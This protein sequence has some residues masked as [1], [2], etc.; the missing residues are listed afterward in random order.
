MK[1]YRINTK[2]AVIENSFTSYISRLVA[3][4]DFRVFITFENGFW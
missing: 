2:E 4:N 1:S 3:L